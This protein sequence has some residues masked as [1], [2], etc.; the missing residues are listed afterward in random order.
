MLYPT[1]FE[2]SKK[3]QKVE[4]MKQRV[5]GWQLLR[6]GGLGGRGKVGQGSKLAV[7]R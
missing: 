2:G 6:A 3:K 7:I 4:V 1:L 5:A